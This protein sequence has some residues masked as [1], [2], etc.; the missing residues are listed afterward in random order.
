MSEMKLSNKEGIINELDKARKN[1]NIATYALIFNLLTPFIS[2]NLFVWYFFGSLTALYYTQIRAVR[3]W[4][5]VHLNHPHYG[6]YDKLLNIPWSLKALDLISKS[7][8]KKI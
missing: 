4:R 3:I 5:L 7:T 8:S 2:A 1:R 6:L